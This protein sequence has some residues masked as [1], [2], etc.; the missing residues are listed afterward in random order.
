[1]ANSHV[2]GLSL[3][4]QVHVMTL[5]RTNENINKAESARMMDAQIGFADALQR[6]PSDDGGRLSRI[7]WLD[8]S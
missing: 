4:T 1:M 8:P 2:Q 3:R 6:V 5:E 7:S